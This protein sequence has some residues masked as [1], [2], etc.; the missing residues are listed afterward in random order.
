VC[1]GLSGGLC[2]VL[3]MSKGVET[4]AKY[5]STLRD[6]RVRSRERV[7]MY[8]RSTCRVG[9]KDNEIFWIE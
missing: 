2:V 3:S 7:L 5:P 6:D 1:T 4:V 9:L 8:G